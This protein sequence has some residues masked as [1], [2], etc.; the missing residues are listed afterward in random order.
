MAIFTLKAIIKTLILKRS[1]F[2]YLFFFESIENEILFNK[3]TMIFEKR[4]IPV[5]VMK[6]VPIVRMFTINNEVYPNT[7]NLKA[8]FINLQ[9]SSLKVFSI[10][11]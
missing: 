5:A 6:T 1:E 10:I 11:D 9:S 4:N 3:Y 2:R 7:S 8:G